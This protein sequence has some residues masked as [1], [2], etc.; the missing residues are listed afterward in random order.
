MW[1]EVAMA[2][3]TRRKFLVSAGAGAGAVAAASRLLPAERG[4]AGTA[5]TPLVEEWIP[6]ACWIGKQ[7]CGMLA[8]RING[9]VVKF[10]GNPLHPRNQGTLCP[11]GM[12]QIIAV[13]DPNRVK[14][15]LVRLNRKGQPGK[16]R[17]VS[18]EHALALVARKIK[19][20]RAKDP[21]LILWQKGRGKS[22]ELYEEAF[23]KAVGASKLGHGVY[24]SDA[25]Y[26]ASEYT[27]GVTGVLHPDFRHTRYLL[28]WGWNITNAGG[29]QLCWIT[30]N[31][32]LLE[33]RERGLK[34]VVIDPRLR[35]AGPFADE[36]L[37]IRPATDLALAL[38]LAH[39][40]VRRGYI[41]REY[42]SRYTNAPFLVQEDGFFLRRDGKEQVW[43]PR[44]QSAKPY[45][46]VRK[47]ALVGEYAVG[48]KKVKPAFQVF[49]E[50]LAAYT[51]QWAAEV[52]GIPAEKIRQVAAE[53]GE[54]ASIGS[55]IE[56][57]G[58]RL[59]YRPV[60]IMAYHMAQQE[61]GFQALRAMLLVTMLVGAPGAVGGQRTE[62]GAWKFDEEKF[63]KLDEVEIGDPP[64]SFTLKDSKFFPINSGS[65][66]IVAKVAQNPKRYGVEKLPEM[67]ILH[68][69]N[70][71]LAAP[72]QKLIKDLY[73][74]FRFV[75]VLSPWLSE[76]ADLFADVILPTAT[77]E[78]YEG[79][80]SASDQYVDAVGLRVPPMEPLFQSRSEADI[81]I[82]LC[83]KA[84]VLYGEEGYIAHLNEALKLVE[85]DKETGKVVSRT[86][87]ALPLHRKPK[88]RDI[89]DR[90][91][92]AQGIKEGI[93]YFEKHG[94]YVK[95]PITADKYY[96]YALDPPFG[97]IRHRLYGESLLR[98]RRE[99]KAKGAEE[100][101]WRDY[102]PLP[103]WRR[104][105]MEGSPAD[106]DLYLISYKLIEH[107][108][109]RSSFIPLLA[110]IAREQALSINPKT[111]K[112]RGIDD[113]DEVWVE[114]H[115]AVTGE[116][117]KVKVRAAYTE[118]IRPDT[119]GL[120]HH[121]GNWTHPWAK[122]QGPSPN[123][124]LF[125]GEGYTANTGDQSFHVK[126]RVYKA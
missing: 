73:S 46:A 14:A 53:L 2:R 58:L 25:G 45:D 88:V 55:T 61:L 114:S 10:E 24:C 21:S 60:G 50:H 71:V 93:R 74:R 31:R 17:Q 62:V 66:S 27:V 57:D 76:T 118:T 29:N 104:P 96:G 37:P 54:A 12:A 51:P 22:K 113:G 94:V 122:G 38:A 47:P 13:Y 6:T 108:Q 70:P 119:V 26:R 110:E 19:E 1:P 30:W 80:H 63:R 41:D 65:P 32:Q 69:H 33:A 23:V 7:D 59:P 79:P 117:R 115:N 92:K 20:V 107:K 84:G 109:S 86:P 81:Y 72:D 35:G 97:G 36:W 98:Y 123:E 121:F 16:W 105:T 111:A 116:T 68:M 15:P 90:W 101:Y 3:L 5:D 34:V 49:K 42:L 85:V 8:R 44:S 52:T 82:D 28:S 102:T 126:V 99:M 106:Y 89:F 75:A 77:I 11:K 103:T 40:L 18:W 4:G 100:I 9:R 95:G 120:S 78:K 112:E 48:G 43:D 64:Y 87:Y 91:A 125:A 39:E 56:V 83:E 124:I 67:V